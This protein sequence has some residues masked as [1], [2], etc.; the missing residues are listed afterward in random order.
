MSEEIVEFTEMAQNVKQLILGLEDL[1]TSIKD[2]RS[3]TKLIMKQYAQILVEQEFIKTYL[4]RT[5]DIEKRHEKKCEEL[6]KVR[7]YAKD[8]HQKLNTIICSSDNIVKVVP[9]NNFFMRQ[10]SIIGIKFNNMYLSSTSA[11]TRAF[12]SNAMFTLE[13]DL[14]RRDIPAYFL[15]AK[16]K[17]YLHCHYNTYR[18][19]SREYEKSAFVFEI[20]KDQ[21]LVSDSIYILS[22]NRYMT[23]ND[24]KTIRF[25]EL[26]KNAV[27]W[28]IV[29]YE[30]EKLLKNL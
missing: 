15:R 8:I 30:T 4:E 3:N 20:D 21:L 27:K 13:Q 10:R 9:S 14:Y 16:S 1:H 5:S 24:N 18:L 25:V 29:N 7:G 23:T 22:R 28:R 26:K 11:L 19:E 6:E 12:N 17:C 2:A